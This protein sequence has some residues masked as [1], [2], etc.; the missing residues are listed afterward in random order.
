[1]PNE[2]IESSLS[3]IIEIIKK[4][5]IS[6]E[7]SKEI[8]DT[9]QHYQKAEKNIKENIFELP[10]YTDLL[11]DT[12]IV[13]NN[14][15]NELIKTLTILKNN[16]LIILTEE[17]INLIKQSQ[18]FRYCLNT[19]TYYRKRIEKKIDEQTKINAKN[20]MI[21]QII[22][23]LEMFKS[24]IID[25][26]TV[27]MIYNFIKENNISKNDTEQII[28]NILKHNVEIYEKIKEIN[29]N[30]TPEQLIELFNKY[31]YKYDKVPKGFKQRLLIKG[32]LDNIEEVFV[33]L[34][35]HNITFEEK[36]K[37]HLCLILKSDKDIIEKIWTLSQKYSF[38][39]NEMLK[40]IP[41]IFLHK[42]FDHIRINYNQ[43]EFEP[44]AEISGAF[45]D[46][47][48]NIKLIK[49]LGYDIT[50]TLKNNKSILI[51][52]NN[53]L[54]RN[55]EAL[56]NYGFPENLHQIGLKLSGLKGEN[57]IATIDKFIELDELTYVQ[58]NTSRLSLEPDSVIFYRLYFA[59][60]YNKE[61]PNNKFTIKRQTEAKEVFTGIISNENDKT[62]DYLI[63]KE[64][65]TNY[66]FNHTIDETIKKYIE[67]QNKIGFENEIT[68]DDMIKSIEESH[69]YNNASYMFDDIIISR[70]KVLRIYSMIFKKFDN[71][72][73]Q[74]LL[75]FAI[76]YNSILNHEEFDKIKNYIG[77]KEKTL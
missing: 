41:G 74:H 66:V 31:E 62:L 30:L 68:I 17:Q 22:Q 51:L 56:I 42:N 44:T 36:N 4:Y 64:T 70:N 77:I 59:K 5:I 11:F 13:K 52:P 65:I 12:K 40:K 3:I 63:D 48:E 57:I 19:I 67:E 27:N 20:K 26:N 73:K 6:I 18:I 61:H 16:S 49:K 34:H 71:L 72:D 54:K 58:E 35:S 32:D 43:S 8:E 69:K 14:N 24:N 47:K 38:D 76:T 46:F 39:F 55:A 29:Y 7:N 25:D 50:E 60:K 1:M 53:K 15:Y 9:Y 23:N 45:E 28:T 75:L 2:N 37:I 10:N 21:N 33:A